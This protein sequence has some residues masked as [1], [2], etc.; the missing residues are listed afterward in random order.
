MSSIPVYTGFW[1]DYTRDGAYGWTLTL[2]VKWSA[3]LVSA[4]STF[5]AIV[6]GS[7]WSLLAFVIHQWRARPGE[8]DGVYFQQQVVYRNPMSAWG[9]IVEL[10]KI[11]GAWRSRRR[12]R[13]APRRLVRR[14]F[15]FLLP[16][17]VVVAGFTAAGIFVG[18]VTRPTYEGN[19]V[20]IKPVNCGIVSFNNTESPYEIQAPWL[21]YVDDTLAARAYARSCY[22]S[23]ATPA[24]CG[25][26]PKQSLPYNQANVTCP[27]GE[28][29]T[30]KS[31]CSV[32]LALSL[33]SGLLDTSD[34]LGINVPKKDRLLFRRSSTCSP[35]NVLEYAELNNATDSAAF[36]V[37]DYYLGPI[38]EQT[39]FTFEYNTQLA[40]EDA[41]P[42]LLMSVHR[43]DT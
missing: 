22:G 12:G 15:L 32:D 5:V 19:N 25:E 14:S 24:V 28:D 35:I 34:Y 39:N 43:F 11:W 9:V 1:H 13:A 7:F 31:L 37:Y 36:P 10:F 26:Y 29:P 20:K 27:F 16:P 6:A 38:D 41:V 2:N 33:D 18:D 21:K 30:G 23:T 42:Y 8:E 17:L 3:I 4:L 40:H